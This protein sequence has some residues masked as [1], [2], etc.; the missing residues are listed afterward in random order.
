MLFARPDVPVQEFACPIDMFLKG[1]TI[2]SDGR[3]AHLMTM[4]RS[5]LYLI[6]INA[7]H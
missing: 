3:A 2:A 5:S 1:T 6:P 7:E 4:T